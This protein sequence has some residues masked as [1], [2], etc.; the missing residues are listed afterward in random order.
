MANISNMLDK[1]MSGGG[2]DLLNKAKETWGNQSTGTQGAVAGGLLAVLLGA[3]RGGLGSV[4]KVGAAAAIGSVASRAYADYKAGKPPLDAISDAIG[5]PEGML[6]GAAAPSADR[7]ER[8]LRA[9]LAAARADGTVSDDERAKITQQLATLGFPDDAKAL[10]E[11]E[12]AV[13]ADPARIAALARDDEEATQIYIA[14]LLVVD[15]EAPAEKAWLDALATALK[16]E[17]SLV[18][19]LHAHAGNLMLRA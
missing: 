19:H 17:P 8:L 12:L 7:A 9:M 1:L 3:G 10:I 6:T 11:E 15:P 5:L 14:S 16:L 13:P 2:A 18:A 4:V